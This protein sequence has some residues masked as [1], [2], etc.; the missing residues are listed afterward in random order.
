VTD[1]TGNEWKRCIE[2]AFGPLAIC[3][4]VIK[5]IRKNRIV[6]VA[7]E[8][9]IGHP[10]Q[11][12]Q[13]LERSPCSSRINTSFIERL[14]LTIRQGSSYLGRRTACFSREIDCFQGHLHLLQCYYN[15]VKYH[16]SLKCGPFHLTPA[17]EAGIANQRINFRQIFLFGIFLSSILVGK[18]EVSGSSELN[19]RKTDNNRGIRIGDFTSFNCKSI[20]FGLAA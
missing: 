9:V 1:S 15:F 7:E 16:R 13:L 2:L 8:L 5:K 14:N 10:Y 11:L 20:E 4:Q 3:A 12:A 18:L 6:K 17:M 19:E